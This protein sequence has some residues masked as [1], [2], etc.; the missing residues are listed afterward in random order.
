MRLDVNQGVGGA[1]LTGHKKALELGG[2]ISVVMAGDAQMDPHYLPSLLDPIIEEGYDFT[3]GN[4]FLFK[5]SLKGMPEIRIFGNVVLT[6]L[7]KFSSG[8]WN[9][10]DPQNGYTAINRDSL[11]LLDLDG[12]S[13][14]FP[15]EN[16][17]LINLN[18]F[19]RR[20]KDV[21]IPAR[22]GDEQSYI[23]LHRVI[24]AMLWTLFKGYLHRVNQKYVLRG[25]SPIAL[26]LLFGTILF[27]WGLIFGIVVAIMTIGPPMASTGTVMLSILPLL[28][29]FQLLLAAVVL[30][31]VETPK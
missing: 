2:D 29:G 8:Y 7:T 18:I 1:I 20:V 21:S 5:D 3:K 27:L 6:F 14:G 25:F 19:N 26:F 22:Y 30:D 28:V 11:E 15:F 31:I 12:I 16:D 9:I 17:L 13:K 24:P 23:K 4:R 10:F